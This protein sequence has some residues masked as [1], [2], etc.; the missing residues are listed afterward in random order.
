M[1]AQK[2]SRNRCLIHAHAAFVY[3]ALVVRMAAGCNGKDF[4]RCAYA[5][6]AKNVIG[7]AKLYVCDARVQNGFHVG[8]TH[9]HTHIARVIVKRRVFH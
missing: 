7:D 2:T 5:R 6:Q 4:F 3:T 9:A 8:R 1:R